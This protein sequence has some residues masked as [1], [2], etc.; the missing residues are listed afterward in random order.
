MFQALECSSNQNRNILDYDFL[1]R[2]SNPAAISQHMLLS[3][4]KKLHKDKN[5]LCKS[6]CSIKSPQ[7][8]Y[9]GD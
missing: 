6:M 7:F 1:L 4:L 9:A 3:G 5:I 8:H 2:L